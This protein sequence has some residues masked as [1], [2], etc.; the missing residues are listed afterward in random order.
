MKK[1][2][3]VPVAPP[4]PS[5]L[6]LSYLAD[7]MRNLLKS[8]AV[9]LDTRTDD[10]AYVILHDTKLLENKL[11]VKPEEPEEGGNDL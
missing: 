6:P 5:C 7:R 8:S 3:N 10:E 1:V 2:T 9:S 4:R 11:G